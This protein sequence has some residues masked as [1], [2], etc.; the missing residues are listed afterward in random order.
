MPHQRNRTC[1]TTHCPLRAKSHP[2][3]L[4]VSSR[5]LR[6]CFFSQAALKVSVQSPQPRV[7]KAFKVKQLPLKT[8]SNTPEAQTPYNVCHPVAGRSWS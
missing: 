5:S 2:G 8:C 4:V 7:R 1:K 6:S 3:P